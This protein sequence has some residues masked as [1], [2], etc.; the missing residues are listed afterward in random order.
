M[1]NS[2]KEIYEN[3]IV[4]YIDQLCSTPL[5]L[6]MSILDV[7]I[8]VY[9]FYKLFQMLKGTRAWQL[10]KGIIFLIL[11]TFLSDVLK[12]WC[13]YAHCYFSTRIKKGIRAIRNE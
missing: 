5:L 6:I 7:V 2:I 1:L 12:L 4:A 11:G 9:L 10:S 13:F 3:V 8:V